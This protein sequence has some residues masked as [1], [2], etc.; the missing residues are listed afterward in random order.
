MEP[1]VVIIAI[2]GILWLSGV[3]EILAKKLPGKGTKELR[4]EVEKLR[5]EV[6][7]LRRENHDVILSF[8]T[9]LKQHER[10]LERVEDVAALSG[11]ISGAE[12]N[13]TQPVG[14]LP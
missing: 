5:D 1:G 3:L 8:D 6:Q 14:R 10:R 2:F 9:T 12:A 11:A 7:A 13:P 4:A